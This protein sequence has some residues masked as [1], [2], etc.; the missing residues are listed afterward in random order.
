MTAEATSTTG[1]LIP[2]LTFS[3]S[4]DPTSVCTVDASGLVA[5]VD[6][7]ACTVSA[8]A[9]AVAGSA[10][11]TVQQRAVQ[12]SVSPDLAVLALA[13]TRSMPLEAFDALGN[14]IVSPTIT[15]SC[16]DT[17]IAT[18]SGADVTGV[19]EGVTDCV[20]SSDTQEDTAR[21]AVVAQSGFAAI[22]TTSSATYRMTATSGSM[23]EADLWMIRPAGGDG[24]LGSIQGEL[25]W[26]P[27]V[28]TYASSAGVESGWT[29]VPNETNVGSGT[30]PFA[31][32]SATGTAADFV[33]ARVTFD[34]VGASGGSTAL[35]LTVSTAGDALGTNITALVQVVS[36]EVRIE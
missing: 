10:A 24:D 32:F 13:E 29:W 35:A 16:L 20:F 31:A 7:G 3:W 21:V 14:P 8:E 15:S 25:T 4:A 18:A 30:L 2:G 9:D 36:S 27:A 33:V 5:A 26:D 12:L 1:R 22:F 19:A 34:V 11:V 23:V 28:V 6:N 17:G